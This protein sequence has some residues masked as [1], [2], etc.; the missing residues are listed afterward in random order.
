MF[1]TYILKTIYTVRIR[2]RI[3]GDLITLREIDLHLARAMIVN[4]KLSAKLKIDDTRFPQDGRIKILLNDRNYDIRVS[5]IPTIYGENIVLRIFNNS[6]TDFSLETIGLDDRCLRCLKSLSEFENGLIVVAGST[7]SGKTTTLYSLLKNLSSPQ[8]KIVT[9][10]DPIEYQLEHVNQV[11]VNE[12]I[13]LTFS[14]I[15]RFLLRQSPN[16]IFI[17]EIRDT[18]TAQV[19]IQ[20]ALTGHLV[21]SSIHAGS[22]EEAITR[23]K[24]L[25]VS[26]YLVNSCLRAVI[27]QQLVKLKCEICHN[28][29]KEKVLCKQCLGRGYFGRTGIFE[30]LLNKDISE[31]LLESC[32]EDFGFFCKLQ[33]S[34]SALSKQD[35]LFSFNEI[36]SKE[37]IF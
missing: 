14:K 25:G 23:L 8:K 20:A 15:I 13:G 19:T 5:L 30:I 9:V 2:G 26:N 18:N 12:E 28:N 1:L 16:V 3:D 7:G 22:A 32:F 6:E 35:V 27:F 29:S 10:E 31:N 36:S 33:D 24:D 17:G 4:I 11:A 21:L 37:S 34:I